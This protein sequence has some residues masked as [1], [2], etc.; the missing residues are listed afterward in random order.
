ML[1][2]PQLLI[3]SGNGQK[4]GKTTLACRLINSFATKCDITA[5]KI[6]PHFHSFGYDLP[7]I[8]KNEEYH[9]FQEIFDAKTKDSSKF[10]KAG[11]RKVY[12]IFTEKDALANAFSELLKVLPE[13]KPII[14]ESGGL[15]HI[16][17]PGLH[18][19]VKGAGKTE[20]DV[21]KPNDLEWNSDGVSFDF[22]LHKIQW[23]TD[24][25]RLSS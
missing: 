3:I 7:A 13:K 18:L 9:I 1:S 6:S 24:H 4:V 22:P 11:A 19:H 5:I 16:V 14:C 12:L 25:W 15:A 23:D 10:L 2:L 20:K 21:D 8:A 17:K